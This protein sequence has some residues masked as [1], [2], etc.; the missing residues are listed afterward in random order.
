MYPILF[1]FGRFHVFSYGALIALGGVLSSM[2]WVSRRKQMGMKREED[3]WLLINVIL[4]GGFLGGRVLFLLEYVRP[5]SDEF[6]ATL[7]SVNRGFSVMGAFVGVAGGVYLL[8]R[9]L[10]VE[11]LRLLDYVCQVAP[12]WHVFGRL[13]CFMAGCCFGLP[14]TMPWGV[15]FTNESSMIPHELLGTPLHPTQ[16]YEAIGNLIIAAALYFFVLP[17][18]EKGKLRPG[19][20]S[21]CYFISYGALRFANEFFRGDVVPTPLLGLTAAQGFSLGLAA[22]AAAI[23]AVGARRRA[24]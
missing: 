18:L 19:V 5:W 17:R 7:F 22:L 3:V 2:F 6:W 16:L 21:A 9:R 23:L 20:L 15:R 14:T 1:S 12:F 13:G 24:A 10:K 4:F 8:A 11:P